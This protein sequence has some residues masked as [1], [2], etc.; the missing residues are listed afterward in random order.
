MGITTIVALFTSRIVLQQLG[1][2]DYG[3]Y[4]VVGGVV[5]MIGF[6]TAS[7][8][9][10]IQRF[11]NFYSG[12]NELDKISEVYSAGVMLVMGL[13]ILILFVG[14]T[15]GLWFLNTQLNLPSSRMVAA[16][17]VYQFSL[18]SV[19]A[20]L[21]QIPHMAL[22]IA[23]EEMNVY[24]YIS[25]F[26]VVAKCLVAYILYIVSDDKLIVYA[27][28][29]MI[30]CF[31]LSVFYRFYCH[32][33]YQESHF[34]FCKKKEI[35][36]SLATFSGWNI[37]GTT[38][39]MCTISGINILLNIFWGTLINA[40]RAIS[41]QVSTCVDNMIQNVQTAMNPQIVKL[42]S[43]GELNAMKELML[44]NFK[45]NVYLF[46]LIALPLFIEID[47]VLYLWLGEVPVYTSIFIR[48]TLIRCM[49]KCIERPLITATF[50]VG[51][52][53]WV[54]IA[55]SCFLGLEI[56]GAIILF[57]LG[58]P[59]YWCFIMDLFA[60]SGCIIYDMLFLRKRQLF[61]FRSFLYKVAIPVS[62]IIFLSAS[63]T[64][65]V[66]YIN[67]KQPLHFLLTCFSSFILSAFFIFFIGM[68]MNERLVVCSKIKNLFRV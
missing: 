47:Y 26:E 25:I 20:S 52:M 33:K 41:V 24:A 2:S 1:A 46:W 11:I 36:I 37:L 35:Y 28:L 57:Y 45:W 68:N 22:I 56:I 8:A 13:A 43:S 19:V 16:N 21:Y 18:I 42:Y 61:S 51:E 30:I 12:T 65:L 17:W 58:F 15:I 38:A 66:C 55:S 64:I 54:N 63:G 3:I 34:V 14:E 27:G 50:A 60:V 62:V 67:D 7:L 48:I 29:L 6:L 39:N 4:N 32:R 53:K 40:A 49:L 44:D 31:L 10:G 5:A 23:H 59:P 9:Q